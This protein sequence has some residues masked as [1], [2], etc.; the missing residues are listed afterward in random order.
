VRCG[1]E[2]VLIGRQGDEQILA[3]ELADKAGTIPWEIFTGIKNRVERV[4]I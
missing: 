1:D 3:S 2:A 4:Y